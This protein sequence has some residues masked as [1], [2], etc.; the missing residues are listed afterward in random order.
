VRQKLSDVELQRA[1]A[2]LP[3]W[4][5]RA[6]TLT[7]TF[8]RKTFPEAISLVN[9]VADEAE[10]RNHHPDIDIRYTKITFTLSTHDAGGVTQ[11]DLD[12]GAAI[13]KLALT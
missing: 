4:T 12:L 1:L 7:K 8:Q 11:S 3:G 5:R 13:E 2:A 10:K 9:K 6:D